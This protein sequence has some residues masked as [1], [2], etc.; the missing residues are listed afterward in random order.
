MTIGAALLLIMAGAILRFAVA[1]A[2]THGIDLHTIGDILMIVG[3]LGLVLW[4]VIWA[5][6]ARTRRPAARQAPPPAGYRQVPPDDGYRQAASP[7]AP[8]REIYREERY[9]DPYPR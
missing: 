8:T 7:D 5:P 2:A 9:E 3:V 1:T 4:L 6:W